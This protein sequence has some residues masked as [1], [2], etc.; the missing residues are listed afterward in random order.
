VSVDGPAALAAD[1][2]G[3]AVPSVGMSDP[4]TFA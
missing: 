1:V 3:G 4:S 2:P